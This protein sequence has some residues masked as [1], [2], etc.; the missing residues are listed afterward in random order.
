MQ[1]KKKAYIFFSLSY[2]IL[3]I[4]VELSLRDNGEVGKSM[5]YPD[6]L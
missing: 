5:L 1:G 2:N 4:I 6:Q 3:K